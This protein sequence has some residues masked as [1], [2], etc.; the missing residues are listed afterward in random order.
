[1]LCHTLQHFVHTL[2]L[3]R[4][5]ATGANGCDKNDSFHDYRFCS[6]TD[7]FTV[8]P[9]IYNRNNKGIQES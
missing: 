4:E 7:T 6:G 3:Q 2:G 1:M 8:H 5:Q 9:F